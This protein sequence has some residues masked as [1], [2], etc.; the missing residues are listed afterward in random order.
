MSA[1]VCGAV[2]TPT[3]PCPKSCKKPHSPSTA[4]RFIRDEL[5]LDGS[6][7]LR[8]LLRRTPASAVR[9]SAP[10]D[11]LKKTALLMLPGVGLFSSL[12]FPFRIRPRRCFWRQRLMA[13]IFA[14]DS[15]SSILTLI[16]WCG[17]NLPQ[18]F[19][20][21]THQFRRRFAMVEIGRELTT[22]YT[23]C[24]W[25]RLGPHQAVSIL[26]HGPFPL[27]P[28]QFIFMHHASRNLTNGRITC[29]TICK[30]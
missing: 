21:N 13:P 12:L 28:G 25:Q 10:Q 5:A 27:Q 30:S 6:T 15:V 9:P 20:A 19:P 14:P 22:N 26:D 23:C 7:I 1:K 8:S 2:A 29:I 3:R 11:W 4:A 17:P 16:P 24:L 18:S